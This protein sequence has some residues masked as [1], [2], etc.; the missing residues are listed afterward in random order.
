V[1]GAAGGFLQIVTI[2][3]ALYERQQVSFENDQRRSFDTYTDADF[4]R[5]IWSALRLVLIAVALACRCC[6]GSWA[7]S[8]GA[9]RGRRGSSPAPG[10]TSGCA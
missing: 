5:T 9:V 10:C 3:V 6:G 7:G 8:R 4:K 2:A 1:L